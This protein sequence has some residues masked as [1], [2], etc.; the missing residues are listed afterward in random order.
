MNRLA[1]LL[2]SMVT[3]VSGCGADGPPLEVHDLNIFAPL[4]GSGMSAAYMILEN[5][6]DN[7]IVLA[8]ATSPAFAVAE[9]HRTSLA[10]GVARMAPVDTIRVPAQGAIRLEQGALHLMLMR[11]RAD[12]GPGDAVA[13]TLSYDQGGE[14][15][16][17]GEL[18]SRSDELD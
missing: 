2:L 11:P 3:F 9:F 16:V 14:I 12:L 17:T 7:A 18:K 13:I 10:D 8:S 4:P 6:T 1:G 5:H 15:I